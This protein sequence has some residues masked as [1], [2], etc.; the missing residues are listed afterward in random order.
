MFHGKH[1]AVGQLLCPSLLVLRAWLRKPLSAPRGKVRGSGVFACQ[2][3]SP[4]WLPPCVISLEVASVTPF[5]G[6]FV[7]FRV[8]TEAS[9]QDC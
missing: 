9:P 6:V 4:L 1:L 2:P 7:F 3:V 8:F 5:A